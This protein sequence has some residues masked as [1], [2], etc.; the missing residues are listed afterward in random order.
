MAYD[1]FLMD[2]SCLSR[3]LEAKHYSF[4]E[5]KGFTSVSIDSRNTEPGSFFI[6]LSGSV[7][8][9]HLYIEAAF[10]AGAAGAM[11]EVSKLQQFNILETAKKMGKEI[12]AVDNTLYA[13]QEAA[14]IYLQKFPNLLKIGITG[15]AGKTTTKEIAAAI[16]AVEKNTV[17]SKGNLNSETGLPLAV[18]SVRSHHEVGV[19]ELAM[20][21][22]GEMADLARIVKPNIALITNIG[23]AHI[24]ILGSKDAIAKEK[25]DIFSCLTDNDVALIPNEDQYRDFLAE[26]VKGTVRFYSANTFSEFEG[27]RSLGLEGSEIIWAGQKVHF[28][29]PGKHCLADALAAIA[30]AKEA[31][32]SNEAIKQGLESVKPMFGRAEIVKGRTTLIRDCY[33]ASPESVTKALEFC[34]S[35]EWP[36]RRIYVMADML[37]LGDNSHSAHEHLGQLLCESKADIIFLFG[38]EIKAAAAVLHAAGKPFFHTEDI[39]G[40]SA[41]VD[42]AIKTGESANGLAQDLVL[43]K[44]SRGCALERLSG[45]LTGIGNTAEA[46]GG[47]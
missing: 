37:E 9:G 6:A 47:S 11:V 7:T 16:I 18:F 20:N 25:K 24:G 30:I 14:R 22:K 12:I 27:A 32:V 28:S 26:N 5:S 42:S 35:L 43:L 10:K 4:G 3:S 31:G 38:K 8:D 39:N 21:H 29:R 19:F 13:L 15:S 40:L 45:I 17:M 1:A 33:N 23:L 36:G 44:G 2:F 34:D 46:K 41:A